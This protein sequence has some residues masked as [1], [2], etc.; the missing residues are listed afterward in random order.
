VPVAPTG[1]QATPFQRDLPSFD[2]VLSHCCP[3][4]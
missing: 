3:S 4:Q 1:T 2:R